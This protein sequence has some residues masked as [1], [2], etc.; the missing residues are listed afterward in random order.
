[1]ISCLRGS[2]KS[3]H[4][5]QNVCCTPGKDYANGYKN[6]ISGINASKMLCHRRHHTLFKQQE[7]EALAQWF[8]HIQ[9]YRNHIK[10]LKHFWSVK[11]MNDHRGWEG[12]D[13]YRWGNGAT[14]L[15]VNKWLFLFLEIKKQLWV[16]C[17]PM[18]EF[19]QIWDAW[20]DK[21][22]WCWQCWRRCTCKPPPIEVLW[23]YNNVTL[24][25]SFS[26][27]CKEN[28]NIQNC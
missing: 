7:N 6:W 9:S 15:L 18:S 16:N 21:C 10:L 4:W 26:Q 27:A 17:P 8:Q 1:M 22:K 23:Q 14:K 3:V 5:V 19:I 2:L 20:N 24:G 13:L 11:P 28:E 12:I 25:F